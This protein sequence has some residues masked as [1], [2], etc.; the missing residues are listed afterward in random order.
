MGLENRRRMIDDGQ[1]TDLSV[2]HNADSSSRRGKEICFLVERRKKQSNIYSVPSIVKNH[3]KPLNTKS[4]FILS[5]NFRC[6]C[7][8][9]FT[10]GDIRDLLNLNN[11]AV[12]GKT[13]I[14][15]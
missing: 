5:V 14:P 15:T 6:Y 8:P 13:E 2:G 11:L 7:Y 4:D 12:S 3:T 10:Y 1:E 9:H